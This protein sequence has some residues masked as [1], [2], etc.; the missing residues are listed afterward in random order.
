MVTLLSELERATTTTTKETRTYKKQQ[1]SNQNIDSQGLPFVSIGV[2]SFT[3]LKN[4]DV[5][6]QNVFLVHQQT[7]LDV[8]EIFVQFHCL[9]SYRND[10]C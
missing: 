10:L 9:S 6:T 7:I 2:K 4:E 3:Y 1:V 5:F 8:N